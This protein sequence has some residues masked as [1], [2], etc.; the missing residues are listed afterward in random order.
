[1]KFKLLL[2]TSF[3]PALIL[4]QQKFDVPTIDTSI[5]SRNKAQSEILVD[6]SK[7]Q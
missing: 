4:A 1:M 2:A 3:I 5:A 7:S 6:V